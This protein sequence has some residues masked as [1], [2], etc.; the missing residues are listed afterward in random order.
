MTAV[1]AALAS[2]ALAALP[3]PA[4]ALTVTVGDAAPEISLRV[5]QAGGGVSRVTFAVTAAVAGTGTPVLGT[6]TA[7]AGRRQNPNFGTDCPANEVRIWA[8]ARSTA[9]NPRTATLTVNGSG[10]LTSGPNAIPFTNFDWVTSGGAEIPSGTFT[11]SPSQAL[12]TFGTS[13]EVSVCQ[14]FR[15]LNTVVYP[16]GTYNGQLTYSLQMP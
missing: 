5:G 15:F 11:G 6:T 13:R 14:R 16:A 2:V 1:R 3:R 8:R 7:N 12:L 9:A 4:S 10:S